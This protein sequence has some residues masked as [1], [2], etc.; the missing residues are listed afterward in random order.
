MPGIFLHHMYALNC[1][2]GVLSQIPSNAQNKVTC[3]GSPPR[4]VGSRAAPRMP[5]CEH[6]GISLH[7]LNTLHC[8]EDQTTVPSR[9]EPATSLGNALRNDF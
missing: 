6:G 5:T 4:V 2:K 1:V 7:P 3:P 8:Q 9:Q